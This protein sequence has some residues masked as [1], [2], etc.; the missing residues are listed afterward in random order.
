MSDVRPAAVAGRFY[1]GD[2]PGLGRAVAEHLAQGRGMTSEPPLHRIAVMAPHAGYVYSGDVAGAVFAATEVPRRVVVMAPNHTGMGARGA[3]WAKGAF[4][5]P[6]ATIRVDEEL[7]AR[8]I[9]E[10]SGL[11]VPDHR[12]HL[13]EHALEVELPFLHARRPDLTI[14]PAILGNLDEE[15]C[16][17]VG[18]ALARAVASLAEDV[19]VVA[20]SDMSHYLADDVTREIDQR[21]LE[22]LLRLDAGALYRR[23]RDEDISMCGILPATAM[24]AYAVAR[25]ARSA[26]LLRYATSGDAFGDRDRVVG[27]A[28]VLIS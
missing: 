27:Y 7:C 28:G 23:V 5:V 17:A 22:P 4:A 25:G 16:I 3:V 24:V 1:P 6:G 20:S 15:E 19:L 26:T 11:L 10:A 9:A 13:R 2:G 21:A 14:A 12:A 8:W 18:Q